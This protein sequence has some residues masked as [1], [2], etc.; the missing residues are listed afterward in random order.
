MADLFSL[1]TQS[2]PKIATGQALL[3]LDVQND[4]ILRN[5]KLP[6]PDANDDF[7]NKIENLAANFR[8][9]GDIIWVRSLFKSERTVNDASGQGDRVIADTTKRKNNNSGTVTPRKE[10]VETSKASSPLSH[11]E[12]RIL[13]RPSGARVL[14]ALQRAKASN[15]LNIEEDVLT[16]SANAK[17]ETSH[18]TDPE[19]FLSENAAQRNSL[20]E[21][22]GSDFID[23]FQNAFQNSKDMKIVKS[24]YSAFNETALLLTLRAKFITQLYF[25]GC[26]ANLSIYATVVDAVRHGFDIHL[27]EDC[28]VSRS[29]PRHDE[30]MRQMIDLLGATTVLSDSLIDKSPEKRGL[31]AKNSDPCI[32]KEPKADCKNQSVTTEE[33]QELMQK[34]DLGERSDGQAIKYHENK[35]IDPKIDITPHNKDKEQNE[36]RTLPRS[37]LLE[38]QSEHIKVSGTSK[39]N[40]DKRSLSVNDREILAEAI[41]KTA[42]LIRTSNDQKQ[43]INTKALATNFRKESLELEHPTKFDSTSLSGNRTEKV[44]G[45]LRGNAEVE[46]EFGQKSSTVM[47]APLNS[48]ISDMLANKMQKANISDRGLDESSGDKTGEKIGEGDSSI[49]FDLIP[50]KIKDSIEPTRPLSSTVFSRLYHEVQ[51]QK[52]FHVQGEV[53]R[54]VAVQGEIGEDGSMP[55][56]RHPSDQSPPLL[57]FSPTVQLIREILQKRINQPVN[58]VLIQ[59][60]RSGNDY[61]S[62]HSDKTLDI[63]RGSS[64]L[65]VSFGAQR[66]MRLRTKKLLKGKQA[67]ENQPERV[68]QRVPMPHNSM[69]VLGEETNAHWLHSITQDKRAPRDRTEAEKAYEGSRISLTFR[70]VGTFLDS[71][72]EHIWGQGATSKSSER[73]SRVV[74]GNKD[75]AQ[76]M[77]HAFG[78]ENRS[79]I[80][81]W[82][83]TYGAGYNV[84]H[85]YT[86]PPHLPML[87]LSGNSLDDLAT[88]ICLKELN[89]SFEPIEP[90][91]MTTT[92]TPIPKDAA[93][94]A[95]SDHRKVCYRDNDVHHTEIC[96][97]HTILL[98][99]DR[100]HHLDEAVSS[101]N[102]NTTTSSRSCTARAYAYLSAADSRSKGRFGKNLSLLLSFSKFSDNDEMNNEEGGEEGGGGEEEERGEEA[103]EDK[104]TGNLEILHL[105]QAW[106]CEMKDG[107]SF[108]AGSSFTI[109]DCLLWPRLHYLF[110]QRDGST[111]RTVVKGEKYPALSA[112]HDRLAERAS[113]K[114]LITKE[115][116]VAT[117]VKT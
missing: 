97:T 56:Y 77:I 26:F 53:P 9:Q 1:L 98:Y 82:E 42:S 18:E 20:V 49:L 29:K 12:S 30:A 108:A 85:F 47:Q 27:I 7:V 110:H 106:E 78:T 43:N 92:S 87:F 101:S 90:P 89:L 86:D 76:K 25:C 80:F 112:Y 37:A 14:G 59:L 60:Y 55:V 65:N 102:A 62:E 99:L 50:S 22:N 32:K 115:A 5:G 71:K 19:L 91:I 6:I 69:F 52:M 75:L 41:G 104:G 88:L 38:K 13:Q 58:H 105:L 100:Y 11:I 33:L 117:T 83:A 10:N 16:D 93:L 36:Q 95:A 24:H 44:D 35:E 68:T 28:L 64:I 94:A 2:Q 116:A 113:I 96:G 103:R 48:Q 72:G 70:H 21:L 8:G 84:L 61:I 23:K 63:V 109:A 45:S 40:L 3:I 54:L 79:S 57:H 107:R 15:R 66:T 46:S 81:D 73:R 111:Q 4:F 31:N 51:W 39:T 17:T 74:N 67:E 34:V 114:G